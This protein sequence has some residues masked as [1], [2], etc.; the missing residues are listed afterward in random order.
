MYVCMYVCIH[1]NLYYIIYLCVCV[2][3]CLSKILSCI[4]LLVYEEKLN[5][6]IR[7]FSLDENHNKVISSTIKN[8]MTILW[9]TEAHWI[10]LFLSL[11]L[12]LY[13]Y[14][15]VCVCVHVLPYI[16]FSTLVAFVLEFSDETWLKKKV[17]FRTYNVSTT[18]RCSKILLIP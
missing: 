1:P 15:Y 3:V 16:Y 9:R 18:W 2:C 13:I 11:S 12:S 8:L 5:I 4:F 10:L 6:L 7:F 17:L 14:I